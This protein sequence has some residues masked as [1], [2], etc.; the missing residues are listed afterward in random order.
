MGRTIR[1]NQLV[2]VS[3]NLILAHYKMNKSTQKLF[4]YCIKSINPNADHFTAGKIFLHD[5]AAQAE[6]LPQNATRG[7]D[8][9][10]NELM[11]IKIQIHTGESFEKYNLMSFIGY[12]SKTGMIEY[13]FNE[14]MSPFLLGLKE[15][16]TNIPIENTLKFQSTYSPRIYQLLYMIMGYGFK[17]Y[18]Y[19]LDEI[20]ATF[21]IM[22][23]EYTKVSDL[24]RKVF[25]KAMEE[26]NSRPNDIRC[27]IIVSGRKKFVVFRVFT[28]EE[29][30]EY[31]ANGRKESA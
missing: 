17:E 16:F 12:D 23:G 29:Y 14:M 25:D 27:D 22:A 5:F 30:D 21:G 1:K 28:L 20:R 24:K 8:G 31:L 13:Q 4:L 2:S 18:I 7:I 6:I 19:P 10:T 11:D 9:W 26:I 15:K 3:N